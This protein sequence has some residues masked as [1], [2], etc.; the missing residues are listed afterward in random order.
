MCARCLKSPEPGYGRRSRQRIVADTIAAPFGNCCPA[1]GRHG[2]YLAAWSRYDS[3]SILD[4]PL[5]RLRVSKHRKAFDLMQL[6]ANYSR[7]PARRR[8][9]TRTR[10]L[11]AEGVYERETLAAKSPSTHR[12]WPPSPA[13]SKGTDG[14]PGGHEKP[15]YDVAYVTGQP[16]TWS[17]H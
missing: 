8:P 10:G 5:A 4:T 3:M 7:S 12:H 11:G 13:H 16:V 1:C 9:S 6:T 2:I 15:K 14:A 17:C